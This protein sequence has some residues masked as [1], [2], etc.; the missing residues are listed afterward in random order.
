MGFLPAENP[1]LL[2]IVVV[3]DPQTDSLSRYGGAVAAP[4]FSAIATEAAAYL[5]LDPRPGTVNFAG[6]SREE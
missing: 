5:N 2:G 3:D 4:I 1:R 6:R